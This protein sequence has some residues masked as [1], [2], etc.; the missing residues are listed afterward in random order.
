MN[1]RAA[2]DM[3]WQE[4]D[5]YSIGIEVSNAGANLWKAD[6]NVIQGNDTVF[7]SHD[8]HSDPIS[9]ETREEAIEAGRQAAITWIES[10]G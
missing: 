5:G 8:G 3:Q 9:T 2:S 6:F 4:H 1:A 7:S 10:N